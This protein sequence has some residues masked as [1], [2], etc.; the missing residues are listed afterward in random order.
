MAKLF[1]GSTN[2]YY[3][4]VA[5]DPDTDRACYQREDGTEGEDY[6]SRHNMEDLDDN[7]REQIAMIWLHD[8]ADYNCFDSFYAD[9]DSSNAYVGIC[10]AGDALDGIDIIASLDF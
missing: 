9:C 4:T 10:S 1:F 2:A 3:I 7:E 6:P 5:I 8:I